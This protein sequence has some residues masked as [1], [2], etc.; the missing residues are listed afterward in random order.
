VATAKKAPM[1]EASPDLGEFDGVPITEVRAAFRGGGDSFSEAMAIRPRIH[2]TGDAAYWVVRTVTGPIDHDPLDDEAK[3][4]K[5]KELADGEVASYRRV[6]DQIF[7]QVI[8]VDESAVLSWLNESA[9]EVA[10]AKAEREEAEREAALLKAE[11]D[12][13][14]A[15]KEAGIMRLVIP[16]DE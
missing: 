1:L 14:D 11:A 7:A 6:E 12:A 3:K 15:E 5:T 8:E 10:K 4:I 16:G 2:Y 9:A 13:L